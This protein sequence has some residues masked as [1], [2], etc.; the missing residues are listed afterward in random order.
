[1]S[2][3]ETCMQIAA[4]QSKL[5][6]LIPALLAQSTSQDGFIVSLLTAANLSAAQI[7]AM[8]STLRQT[9]SNTALNASSTFQLNSFST[10]TCAK[11]L[12]CKNIRDPVYRAQLVALL[13]SAAA[14][15]AQIELLKKMCT[16]TNVQ[17]NVSN[18]KQTAE[19]ITSGTISQLAA[20]PFEPLIQA[21]I[22][23]LSGGKPLECMNFP[24]KSTTVSLASAYNICKNQAELNLGNIAVCASANQSNSADLLQ[25]CVT[26]T[27]IGA[28]AVVTADGTVQTV[29]ST[30]APS[31]TDSKTPQDSKNAT[32]VLLISGVAVIVLIVLYRS[33]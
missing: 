25:S 16:F 24:T 14:A 5:T 7:E 8:R 26:K 10:S 29:K 28:G 9:G 15:D 18:V 11:M 33:L 31:K 2:A 32:T 6:P 30:N 20:Q 21:M 27:A 4:M 23:A 3:K 22:N 1:M 12:G 17:S 19:Q 13:G